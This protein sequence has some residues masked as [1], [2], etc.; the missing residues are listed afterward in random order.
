MQE[1]ADK[2]FDK[3]V[4][5]NHNDKLEKILEKKYFEE[6]AKS[7]LLSMLYKIEAAYKDYEIVKQ[8]VKNK[9][10][11]IEDLIESIQ[12]NCDTIKLVKP[13]SEE[14]K[15]I[16]NKT[17]LVEKRT[18]RIIC[19]PIERK[20]LYSI[21]KISKKDRIV[22][23]KHFIV[24]QT[25]SD[26][27]N[28]GNCINT[29]EPLRD[30]NGY[31]WT[32]I[33]REIESIAHNLI[34]QNLIILVGNEFLDKWIGN[35]HYI[36]DYLELLKNKL[37]E[38][39]GK[40][41]TEEFIEL[42]K[43]I[44]ILLEIKFDKITKHEIEK[45]KDEIENKLEKINNSKEFVKNLTDEKKKITQ[46]IK[47]IDETINN[48]SMLK[49]EYSTRNEMLPLKEK[50]FS[51]KI[52]SKMMEQ[53]R[54]EKI[55]K[56]E[57]INKLLIPQNFVKYKKELEEKEKYLKLLETKDLEKDIYKLLIK[58]QRNFL[59]CFKI[60]IQKANEKQ[61]IVKL[62]YQFRYYNILPIQLG[63]KVNEEK[64]IYEDIKN[65]GK[66]LIRKAYSLKV[67]NLFSKNEETNY[68]ILKN[69]F[70]IRM[71]NLEELY[72]KIHKDKDKY[73]IQLFDDNIFEEKI[74]FKNAEN[75][76][77]KDLEIRIGKKAKVF[78]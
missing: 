5:K 43:Q 22:K 29:V 6:D 10:K 44:S 2:I 45:Q 57:K 40:K 71:I 62:I 21:A 7:L 15:I 39:Y 49:K 56:I 35:K 59:E 14:S 32:T 20:L 26:L 61:D 4:K 63:K 47:D 53:E 73:Y 33:D 68:D 76:N 72:I 13:N 66:L 34:Y 17:F 11:F 42:L 55:E 75:I 1:R 19:Y 65:V 51:I 36:I 69:I 30:F 70:N 46:E 28:V 52:L 9:D 27:I 60:Q 78:N 64:E 12:K 50:I 24:N 38:Y 54:E 31:S 3:I 74:E 48:P 16:G 58:I 18:K 41:L 8:D 37:E 77:K 67:V 25:L 23:D